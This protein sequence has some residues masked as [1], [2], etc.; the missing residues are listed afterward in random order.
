[1]SVDI[2]L[3]NGLPGPVDLPD[4]PAAAGEPWWDVASRLTGAD[5]MRASAPGMIAAGASHDDVVR[6]LRHV[7]QQAQ[8]VAELLAAVQSAIDDGVTRVLEAPMQAVR[9][10]TA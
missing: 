7:D 5:D 6:T 10:V 2:N 4:L 1:M 8:T 3:T 9:E